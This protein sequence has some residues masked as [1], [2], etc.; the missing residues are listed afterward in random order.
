MHVQKP[1]WLHAHDSTIHYNYGYILDV[2]CHRVK[3]TYCPY[4]PLCDRTFCVGEPTGWSATLRFK[5]QCIYD[6]KYVTFC[7]IE[8]FS[9]DLNSVLRKSCVP[10]KLCAYAI[11]MVC[12]QKKCFLVVVSF[13]KLVNICEHDIHYPGGCIWVVCM[14]AYVCKLVNMCR[15]HTFIVPCT[16]DS[17][18]WHVYFGWV[19]LCIFCPSF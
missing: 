9:P 6:Y 18:S 19:V 12:M 8:D 1:H 4:I 5:V 10:L 13:N 17:S 15:A 3:N 7:F 2:A 11:T 16:W 14:L